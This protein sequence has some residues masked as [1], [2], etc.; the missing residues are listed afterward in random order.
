MSDIKLV[1]GSFSAARKTEIIFAGTV[2]DLKECVKA[3][4]ND[5]KS[6]KMSKGGKK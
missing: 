1:S 6:A 4:Q 5:E 3:F 2:A